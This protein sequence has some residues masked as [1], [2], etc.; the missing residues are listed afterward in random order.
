MTCFIVPCKF[1]G[2]SITWALL[3]ARLLAHDVPH[4][5]EFVGDTFSDDAGAQ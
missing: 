4:T 1:P 3:F 2:I 5:Q